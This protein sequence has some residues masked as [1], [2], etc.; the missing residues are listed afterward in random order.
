MDERE[1][2]RVRRRKEKSSFSRWYQR[3]NK[4]FSIWYNNSLFQ[5]FYK[6]VKE[7]EKMKYVDALRKFVSFAYLCILLWIYY[8]LASWFLCEFIFF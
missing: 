2:A 8:F 4:R 5:N 1:E 7:I 6:K 3:Q